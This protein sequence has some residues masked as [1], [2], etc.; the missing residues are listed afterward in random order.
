MIFTETKLSGAYVIDLEPHHDERG[1]FARAWCETE[2]TEHGLNPC[3]KQCNISFNPK[4]GTLRGMHYQADPYGEVKLVRC[5][6]GKIYDVIID[7]RPDSSSYKQHFSIELSDE[8]RRMLYIPEGFA[9]GFQTLTDNVE[10]FYQMAQSYVP[11]AASGIRWN[12]PAFKLEWPEVSNRIISER[13]EQ[14]PDY[15]D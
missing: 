12:D 14:Y 2:F 10:V 4:E 8:N 13:D 11:G 7:I 3:I 15:Q 9:H 6:M 1:F 5:T